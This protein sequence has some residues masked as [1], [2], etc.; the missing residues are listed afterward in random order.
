M[1]REPGSKGNGERMRADDFKQVMRTLETLPSIP[2]VASNIL[3]ALTR[4][5]PDMGR[6]IALLESDQALAMKVLR[7]VNSSF[8]G[9]RRK[10]ADIKRAVTM[11]GVEQLKCALLS[12]TVSESL[13]KELRRRARKDQQRLWEHSLAC[14]VCCEIL[15]EKAG[16]ERVSE[17][18]VVG[19]LHDVGKLVLMEWDAG[20]Y[21][22][23]EGLSQERNVAPV[24][25][26]PQ[27]L[28]VD[29]AT[30]GKWLAEKWELP[31]ILLYPIWWHHHSADVVRLMDVSDPAVPSLS[32]LVNLADHLAH[33][34]MADGTCLEQMGPPD[35][36]LLKDLGLDSGDYEGAKAEVGK[37]YA[38]R[39]SLLDLQQDELSFYFSALQ[40]ANQHLANMASTHLASPT[41]SH[42]EREKEA[43]EELRL[44]LEDQGDVGSVLMESARRL[45]QV[46]ISPQG[47]LLV[48]RQE[49]R[50][51]Q[52][53]WWN[54]QGA[55]ELFTLSADNGESKHWVRQLPEGLRRLLASFSRRYSFGV[56]GAS[57]D[58]LIQFHNPYVAVPILVDGV[59]AGEVV[60][61][62]EA[63]LHDN[64]EPARELQVYKRLGTL[65][66][67]AVS[68]AR[69][70]E[71]ARE[72]EDRLTRAL[73]EAGW[74]MQN[75]RVARKRYQDEKDRLATTLES[76][77]DAVIATDRAGKI[78]LFN[79]AAVRLTGWEEKE[80]LGGDFG[81]HVRLFLT[82][83]QEPVEDPLEQVM[84]TGRPWEISD[85]LELRTREGTRKPVGVVGSPIRG[86][87]GQIKGAIF[88]VRDLTYQKK[89]EAE[90][91]RARKL[92]SVRIL[93]GGIA[94]D[95]NNI[96]M[97]ILG[98]L[99]LAKMLVGQP[100]K[101]EHRISEAEKAVHR[102]KDLTEQLLAVAKGGRLDKRTASMAEI[103]KES[104]DFVLSGSK[105]RL[106]LEIAEDLWP[107]DVDVGQMN[108]VLSNLLL[109]AR[110]A[111]PGG[112]TV[113]VE[114][115]NV[116]VGSED[117]V[118]VPEGRYVLIRVQDQGVGIKAEY[119]DRIFD[120]YFTTKDRGT[121]KG[122]G[123]GLAMVYS[124][125]RRHG[126]HVTVES[127]EGKGTVFDLYLPASHKRLSQV[128]ESQRPLQKGKGRILVMDD[129][130]SVLQ[131]VQEMLHHLGYEPSMARDGAEAVQLYQEA[132]QEG[133]A[134]RAVI[135]D[136]TVRG[137]QGAK[138]TL[139]QIRAI[140]PQ[141]RAIVSSG[142][143]QN[144]IMDRYA[145]FGFLG[146]VPKP[147]TLT[148]L[149]ET[150]QRVLEV[151]ERRWSERTAT[152]LTATVEAGDR[153]IQGKT[154]N[155]SMAGV[156]VQVREPLEPE[157]PVRVTL[158]GAEDRSVSING[159][160]VWA[161]ISEGNG[162]GPSH[163]VGVRFDGDGSEAEE[164]LKALLE[165]RS[166]RAC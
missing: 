2:A 101:V 75:L 21:E 90:V 89:M 131:I 44:S 25:L 46:L 104:G 166:E 77:G 148:K 51:L 123:L 165:E 134:F 137:G 146:V 36:D 6:V 27:E 113:R 83:A 121:E 12:V 119:L 129:D 69:L 140:D 20:R 110:Q 23:V 142:Y 100:E 40:R 126:G 154:K 55:Q 163:L 105:V 116:V 4:S 63:L 58:R 68:R 9:L 1:E 158:Q 159:R 71:H 67:S 99:N 132:L 52:G 64:P 49:S 88:A 124:I 96:M 42:A 130:E 66:A 102:A 19:L 33:D 84:T 133:R 145:D 8:Y 43:L 112:G 108:Q 57:L 11:L 114:A 135:L 153:R 115:R 16:L 139:E 61:L 151:G 164:G 76:I 117:Q 35:P 31:D 70:A 136:L 127:E 93:A 38:A 14:A 86:Q 54:D 120:P 97:G 34:L 13:I 28:G 149:G 50:E 87:D 80:A 141:V 91:M 162:D 65:L 24:R 72:T 143:V 157:Q 18:F 106:D 103:I 45:P 73:A 5:R 79:Q 47:L 109:N 59:V 26:E 144:N 147:Y 15:A 95:F 60:V 7:I 107:V 56:N 85:G 17:A 138:E 30:A 3:N 125:M 98:N 74:A 160:V 81:A 41:P 37:R 122:T 48:M 161:R 53:V 156:L 155:L 92:D 62:E 10:V 32:L 82:Q 29:H 111:M 118:A 39:T 94:H 22:Q 78:T 150:L 128:R 152:R